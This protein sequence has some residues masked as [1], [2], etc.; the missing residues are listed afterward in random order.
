MTP[1][2]IPVAT[3]ARLT[4]ED[5]HVLAGTFTTHPPHSDD[6]AIP[7]NSADLVL[8]VTAWRNRTRGVAA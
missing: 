8:T 1:W 7:A 3:M 2:T 6:G 4:D 5:A